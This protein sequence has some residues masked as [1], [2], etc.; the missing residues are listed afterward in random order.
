MTILR[1]LYSRP[2]YFLFNF[3][4]LIRSFYE[5]ENSIK[6]DFLQKMLIRYVFEISSFINLTGWNRHVVLDMNTHQKEIFEGKGK[7]KRFVLS[8]E[9]N[10]L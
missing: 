1:S 9:Q 7:N 6:Y 2:K 4:L 10:F 8:V 5:L 3:Y